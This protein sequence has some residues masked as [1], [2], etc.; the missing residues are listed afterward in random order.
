MRMIGNEETSDISKH[1]QDMLINGVHMKQ[2]ML[3]LT[4][5]VSKDPQIPTENRSL[6]HQTH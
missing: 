2:V 4:H 1:H 5:N 6:I 3:H